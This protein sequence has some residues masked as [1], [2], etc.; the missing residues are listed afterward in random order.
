MDN[1]R[2]ALAAIGKLVFAQFSELVCD[3]YNNGLPTNLSAGKDPSLDYGLKG[4]EIA[5]AAYCS[6]LQ[7]LANPMITHVQSA[8][9]HNQDVNSL[10]LISAQQSA[11]A[12]EVLQ[13]M[14]AT[15]LVGLSQ[16]IDLSHLEENLSIVVKQL[17][18]QIA[19]KIDSISM[20]CKEELVQLVERLPV[21]SY[22]DDPGNPDGKLVSQLRDVLVQKALKGSGDC[23]E[24]LKMVPKFQEELQ[25][26]LEVELARARERFANGDYVVGMRIKKCKTYP[27]YRF[28]REEVGTEMLTGEKEVSPGEYI[29]KVYEAI[30]EGQIDG[31][32]VECI[33]AL[34]TYT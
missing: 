14:M 24:A 21:F 19:E 25:K 17:V 7:Y 20:L 29:E 6:E 18:L 5:M 8:E 22:I 2:V 16:A 10:G 4:A 3:Y 28:V 1:I 34:K 15:Y 26:G 32:I 31:V 9:Q 30:K 13:L 27:V 33:C 23:T 12:I 11:K